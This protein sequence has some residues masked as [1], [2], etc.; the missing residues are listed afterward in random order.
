MYAFLLWNIVLT[1]FYARLLWDIVKI[2]NKIADLVNEY[3][4]LDKAVISKLDDIRRDAHIISKC[5]E[6]RKQNETTT[7]EES[8]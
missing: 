2:E 3:D 4:C 6:W 7:K 5:L 8:N 1:V